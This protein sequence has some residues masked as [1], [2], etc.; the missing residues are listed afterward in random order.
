MPLRCCVE[1]CRGL[2][3]AKEGIYF[4]RL[5]Q[6]E[7]ERTQWLTAIGNAKYTADTHESHLTNVR[8]CSR[9][10]C[11]NNFEDNIRARLMN[12]PSDRLLAP[13]LKSGAIPS[14]FPTS[15]NGNRASSR[16]A[17]ESTEEQAEGKPQEKRS[18]NEDS[19]AGPSTPF[20][21][22]YRSVPCTSTAPTTT[23]VTPTERFL[24]AVS[25]VLFSTLPYTKKD[26]TA[27][28]P[29]QKAAQETAPM[30]KE[31]SFTS[32]I[33]KDESSDDSCHPEDIPP[34]DYNS[35]LMYK[36]VYCRRTKQ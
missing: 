34:V 20:S 7:G 15:S 17:T 9:H 30:I 8:V 29:P 5:P 21:T 18:R 11:P 23:P 26:D 32:S 19:Q 27:S 12:I 28:M 14:V 13:R 22:Q 10:F 31:E 24:Q 4:Y 36:Q 6:N 33:V 2:T 25:S 1:K 35:N 3:S 16:R